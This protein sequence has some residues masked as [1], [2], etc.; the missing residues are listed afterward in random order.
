[1]KKT[2]AIHLLAMSA[3]ASWA[4]SSLEATPIPS[5]PS[6]SHA[7]F[8][9]TAGEPASGFAIVQVVPH[10]ARFPRAVDTAGARDGRAHRPSRI[11][12]D[13]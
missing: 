2:L 10:N 5:T 3:C 6:G 1:M 11:L 12:R 8:V 9:D 7:T 13:G 4:Q